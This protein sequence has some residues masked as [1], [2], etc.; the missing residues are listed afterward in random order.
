ML[1]LK[2]QAIIFTYNKILIIKVG[3]QKMKYVFVILH[4][5]TFDETK[6]CVESILDNVQGDY[7]I[8]IVDNGSTNNS[9]KLLKKEF[10]K[11]DNIIL[12]LSEKNIGFAEGNNLGY[13]YATKYLYPDFIIC[14]NNDTLIKQKNFLDIIKHNFDETDFFVL[15]PDIIADKGKVHQNPVRN[16]PINKGQLK[17]LIH[18]KKLYLSNLKNRGLRK[19]L[20]KILYGVNRRIYEFY[21]NKKSLSNSMTNCILHGACMIF[22]I[23]YINNRNIAFH[24]NTF[25]YLEEDI[26]HLQC[27]QNSWL[28]V[29]EPKLQIFHLEDISTNY[30]N[31]TAK[32][33]EVFITE[34]FLK[35]SH[36]FLKLLLED[37]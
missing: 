16:I 13:K 21:Y 14:I 30:I 20:F 17:F 19:T 25:L 2:Y 32:D 12:L 7:T 22:S 3:E 29:Y 8:I 24:P 35:S 6:Q 4:Y 31:K 34:H 28:M 23:N 33:K 11:N 9:G 37:R 18:Q 1:D 15:G 10:E 36:E 26:L 27:M 5:M